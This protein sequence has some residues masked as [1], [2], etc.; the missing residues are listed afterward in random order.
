MEDLLTSLPDPLTPEQILSSSPSDLNP[1]ILQRSLAS[2]PDT[3]VIAICIQLIQAGNT[4]DIHLI[5]T[6]IEIGL[7]RSG[8]EIT[9]LRTEVG[10]G[11]EEDVKNVLGDDLPRAEV[12]KGWTLLHDV[13]GRLNTFDVISPPSS[14]EPAQALIIETPNSAHVGD[15]STTG[16]HSEEKKMELDDPWAEPESIEGDTSLSSPSPLDDPWEAAASDK[17]SP[18]QFD[19]PRLEIETTPPQITAPPPIPLSTFLIQPL[20]VSALDLA[21]SAS[22][23]ALSIVCQ[24]H[25]T[26]MYPHRLAILETIPGWVLPSDLEAEG[27]LLGVGDDGSEKWMS[28]VSKLDPP[29]KIGQLLT[30]LYLPPPP[31]YLSTH[32]ELLSAADLN[33][34]YTSH[35]L[36]LDSL[37]LLDIQLAWV[38]YG[39]SLG[40]PSLDELGEDLSLLSRLVY[41]ANLTPDQHAKWNLTFWRAAT[42]GDIINAYLANSTSPS[43][44]G[45]IKRLVMPYLYVLETRAERAGKADPSLMERSLHDAILSLPLQLALPV[46]EAS[47]ATIPISERIV[48]NDL[49]VARLA[50]ACLYGSEEK[51]SYVWSTMSSIFECLPVWELSGSDPGSDSELTATTL[52]SIATFVRPTSASAPPPTPKDLFLFFHP[53]PFASLSRALDILDVH[54]ESGEI[55]ARWNVAT[56]LRFLLQS[57]RNSSDQKELAEKMVRRQGSKGLGEDGWRRLWDDMDRLGG[58]EDSLVRGAL[59]MLDLRE[60]G[61]IYLGGVLSSGNFDVAKR[62]IRRLQSAGAI[63]DKM[64]EEVVLETSKEF[65]V[66]ADSGN[67]HT[68][69]MKLAYDCLSVGPTTSSM[70]KEKKYIEATSRLVSFSSLALSPLEIRHT[71]D[72]LSLIAK[73]LSA[74]DDAYRHPDLMLDMADKLGCN[75]ELE[76]GLVWGMIGRASER[77]AHWEAGKEALEGMVEIVRQF[78]RGRGRSRRTGVGHTGGSNSISSIPDRNTTWESSS[79]EAKLRTETWQL[80][81]ALAS[82]SDTADTS[83]KLLFINYALELCPPSSIPSI[84]ETFRKVESGRI[85][86]DYAAKRR[87]VEGIPTSSTVTQAELAPTLTTGISTIPTAEERV[88]GSRTA[89]KA[90]KLALG[91]GGRIGGLRGTLGGS[92]SPILGGGSFGVGGVGARLSRSISRDTNRSLE[93]GGR[94][95]EKNST[96]RSLDDPNPDLNPNGH[97]V[98]PRELFEGLAGDEAERVRLG[99]RRALVRGVGWLLGADESEIV[100]TDR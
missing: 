27:L 37:G 16:V 59:G 97:G 55:L 77:K 35:I 25:R 15:T 91:L 85:K 92:S 63:D 38:Q 99:A 10:D 28:S 52:D 74:S 69:E 94:G 90:A 79:L 58:G 67:M 80:A 65:Y 8:P 88:L 98:I 5:R 43:V 19:A 57:S 13:K 20:P 48:K 56:Q 95:G 2:I 76:R 36:S 44:V 71:K 93:E 31:P 96:R 83:S 40:V 81:H 34:W 84:L 53:L 78:E 21:A 6:I 42:Q 7:A 12:I 54:L 62:M 64:I 4:E 61:R 70:T 47:K 14:I 73:V 50:L 75:G 60:R 24:R 49:N 17:K 33:R 30:T 46:F 29:S 1:A 51:E 22:L 68:G 66:S 9:R 72:P 82:E 41:D 45:D 100:G 86:L 87:R 11:T 18:A 39:A 26:E 3:E 89:A 32:R 23:S